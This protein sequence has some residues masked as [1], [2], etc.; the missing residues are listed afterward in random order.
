LQS[1][2]V[3]GNDYEYWKNPEKLEATIVP[4]ELNNNSMNH[5][6]KYYLISGPVLASG[7]VLGAAIGAS[8]GNIKIGMAFGV[9]SGV[10]FGALAILGSLL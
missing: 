4:N 10:A 2:K 7:V 8:M 5:K 6:Y 3:N 1:E 9:L